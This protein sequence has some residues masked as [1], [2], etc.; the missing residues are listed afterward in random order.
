MPKRK[1]DKPYSVRHQPMSLAV[2]VTTTAVSLALPVLLAAAPNASLGEAPLTPATEVRRQLLLAY[3]PAHSESAAVDK[4]F[5]QGYTYCDAKV[6]AAFWGETTPYA[7][8]VRLGDKMLQWG[9][10]DA[11]AH[12]P[13]ARAQALQKP[14]S[15]MPCSFID[16]GY[17]Y[18]DAARLATYWGVNEPWEAKLKIARLLIQ[19]KDTAIQTALKSAKASNTPDSRPP[20]LSAYTPEHS[21]RAAVDKYFVQ[22][23]TYCDAKVLAAF[24][25]ETTPYAAKVR[26]GDKMLRWGPA[27]AQAH[28]PDARAQAL[29]KP[30]SEMPCW[31]TDGGYSYDDAVLLATYWGQKSELDAKYK[32]T[33]LLGQ[34]KDTDIQTA[35]KN[36]KAK[37]GP[38]A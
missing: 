32:M 18:D 12:V 24:W 29:Q 17:S 6:L 13:N 9:P 22:G 1:Q 36:A 20:Q 27:D 26:L 2:T 10:A 19:G 8:K 34:G 28:V 21:E 25:G 7:A 30:A 14:D 3:T 31:F 11:Q 4:Y 37:R 38:G 33:R 23:Y 35:L 16:G 15:E 5:A